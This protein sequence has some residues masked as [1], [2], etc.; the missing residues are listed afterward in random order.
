MK[1]AKDITKYQYKQTIRKA[2]NINTLSSVLPSITKTNKLVPIKVVEKYPPSN[3]RAINPIIS[4]LFP[5]IWS[6]V[7]LN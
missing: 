5:F 1:G 6:E 4:I 2:I 7:T 3:V